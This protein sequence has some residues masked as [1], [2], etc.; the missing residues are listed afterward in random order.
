MNLHVDSRRLLSAHLQR[1]LVSPGKGPLASH[2]HWV[3]R[4]LRLPLLTPRKEEHLTGG[5]E[6]LR[7]K[8]PSKIKHGSSLLGSAKVGPLR[9]E[10]RRTLSSWPPSG[11]CSEEAGQS[12]LGGWTPR[13][14]QHH[15]IMKP[16]QGEAT[17]SVGSVT[18]QQVALGHQE[19]ERHPRAAP[20][21]CNP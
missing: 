3:R 4:P 6:E 13:Q 19:W 5:G 2:S 18:S 21:P 12:E 20:V 7:A 9:T 16:P 14:P 8:V 15:R 11:G 17:L 10:A 1:Q